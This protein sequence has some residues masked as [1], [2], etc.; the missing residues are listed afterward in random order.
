MYFCDCN[1][2]ILLLIY[3]VTAIV[4][5]YILVCIMYIDILLLLI[6]IDIA[7]LYFVCFSN[8][9]PFD[10]K[11]TGLKVEMLEFYCQDYYW[12]SNTAFIRAGY[13][14]ILVTAVPL[15][16]IEPRMPTLTIYVSN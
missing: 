13:L 6:Y 14:L 12:I 10:T 11:F 8:S 7:I 4:L 3:I 15:S 16:H 2:I 9:Y 5:I 1:V